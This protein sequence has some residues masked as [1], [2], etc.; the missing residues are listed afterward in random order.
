MSFVRAPASSLMARLG[1]ARP[2]IVVVGAGFA[3]FWA[4][5]AARRVGKDALDVILVSREPKL[6][7]RPR[8]YER[9]PTSLQLAI[10]PLLRRV[11][12][13][14][15]AGEAVGLDV[16][17]DVL[18][19]GDG[20]RLGYSRLVVA[21]GSVMRRPPVPGTD[22]AF[23]IDTVAEAVAFDAHL[24]D[25]VRTGRAPRIAVVGAGFTGLELA[26]ELRDRIRAHGTDEQAEGAQIVLL[27][28]ATV[29]GPELGPGPRPQIEAALGAAR[30]DVR[31]GAT[32]TALDR[33][34]VT[35]A[36]GNRVTVDAVVL[37]TG[38]GAA[39][40]AKLVPG[41]HD[42]LGRVSVGR[43]LR[44]PVAPHIFVAG[45]AAATLA[46]YAHPVI[47]SC[48]HALE[49]GRFAGE[50]AARDLLGLPLVWNVQPPYMTC[51]DLG[52]S[53][54]VYTVGW[55]REVVFTGREAKRRKRHINTEVIYP[56]TEAS[57]EELLALSRPEVQRV[58]APER[59]TG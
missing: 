1:T 35:L 5:V 43:T 58:I 11:A 44:V 25:V 24:A 2:R 8:L 33:D 26:L 17:S 23:S 29:A 57:A 3:G 38:L 6:Q 21:T 41:A 27:E 36:G 20:R 15:V 56:P 10:A 18:C 45:D 53:G 31:L 54:A 52:R 19:L 9:D 22:R 49:L 13:R 40:F 14:F 7:M 48:Q 28:R 47:Q 32:V 59:D 39:P 51:L 55:D 37:T 16:G 34:Q 30:V 12:V 50:N 42:E 4:S 46:D